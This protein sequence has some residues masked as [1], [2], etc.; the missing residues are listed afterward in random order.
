MVDYFYFKPDPTPKDAA[1]SSLI[2]K[3]VYIKRAL[4]YNSNSYYVDTFYKE[5]R[6]RFDHATENANIIAYSHELI[7]INFKD[8]CKLLLKS[9]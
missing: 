6:E 7:P 2:G 8:R 1:Y 5:D 3:V 9:I 4:V